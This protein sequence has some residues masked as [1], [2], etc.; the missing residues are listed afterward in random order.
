MNLLTAKLAEYAL[1]L[2][3]APVAF[4]LTQK[5]KGASDWLDSKGAVVKQGV[6]IA[7]SAGLN[8]VAPLVGG[9]LCVDGLSTCD[10]GHI[11]YKIVVTWALAMALHNA[12]RPKS[13]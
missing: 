3:A 10:L 6:A 11:D 9:P 2:L 7:L 4:W 8:A 13:A 12:T 1:P 5:A